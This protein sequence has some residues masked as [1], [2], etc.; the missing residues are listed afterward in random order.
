LMLKQYGP[1]GALGLIILV[2]MWWR[3]F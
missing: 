1:F 2:F 3:F